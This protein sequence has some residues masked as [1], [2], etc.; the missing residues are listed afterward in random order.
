M[1]IGVFGGTFNPVHNGHLR[2]AEEARQA[3][4]LDRVLFI[5]AGNPPLKEK[6][7][8][9]IQD[10]VL[11]VKLAIADNPS[12]ELSLAEADNSAVSYTVDTLRTLK[13]QNPADSLVFIAGVD[14]FS[15]IHLWKDPDDLMASA[16][17]LVLSRP[18]HSFTTLSGLHY[19]D[20]PEGALRSID[21]GDTR[22]AEGSLRG[23]RTLHLLRITDMGVSATMLRGLFRSGGSTR[24]LLPESV[25]S[26]IMS[27]GL[28]R[29]GL[30]S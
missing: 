30:Q 3:L 2:A 17:F 29:D 24:Y 1:K 11:M 28:Y 18:G 21:S 15:E 9:A 7:L 23:G 13:Q 22:M 12:F 19:V 4:G 6:E 20:L 27:H 10:R 5:P 26:F 8:A 16:D 14:A 25:E